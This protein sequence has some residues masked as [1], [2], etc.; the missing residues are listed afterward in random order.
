MN[1]STTKKRTA[2]CPEC[3]KN[4]SYYP[5]AYDNG[6]KSHCSREC[7]KRSART[8]T[9]CTECGKV[10]WY[11]KSWPRKFCSR[12]CAAA[13][14]A[15]ANLG[16]Y[17][18]GEGVVS[19]I[20]DNCGTVFGKR[21]DQHRKT[22]RHFCCQKCF[23]EWQSQNICGE[24]HPLFKGNRPQYYGKNWRSQ[25]RKARKR[26]DYTCQR[27]GKTQAENGKALDVHHIRPFRKFGLE[28]YEEANHLD[29]LVSLCISCHKF[30]E[31][32]GW[33]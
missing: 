19:V 12:K 3:G 23:G 13:Q 31:H 33:P 17:A 22:T 4:F 29:N 32:H 10:F 7:Q 9:T 18:Q 21:S 27:C 15:I 6:I 16:N 26:D 14:N 20:C 30:V 5:S 28:H 24:H 1:D 25:R 2:V 8:E 11:H